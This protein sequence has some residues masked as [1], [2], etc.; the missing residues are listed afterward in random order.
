MY[1]SSDLGHWPLDFRRFLNCWCWV[2]VNAGMAGDKA[3]SEAV[4]KKPN[5]RPR[6]VYFNFGARPGILF[7]RRINRGGDEREFTLSVSEVPQARFQPCMDSFLGALAGVLRVMDDERPIDELWGLSGLGLRTQI[8]RAL[9][10]GGL[11]ARQWDETYPRMVL[12][13]GYD[14]VAGLRN[15]FYTADDLR[16]LQMT[17]MRTIEKNLEEGRPAISFGLHGPAFGIIRGF[18]D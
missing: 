6:E 9:D 12:R 7:C 14:C 15:H 8:H 10:P 18:D 17:W 3:K 13:S 2:Q 11:L 5:L 4:L 16:E 1:K